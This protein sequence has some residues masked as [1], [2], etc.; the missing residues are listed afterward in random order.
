MREQPF[1]MDVDG[2]LTS[3][4]YN[5]GNLLTLRKNHAMVSIALLLQTLRPLLI[6]T[7]RPERLRDVTEQWLAKHGLTPKQ[8]YMRPNDEEGVPDYLIKLEHLMHIRDMHGEPYF[9]ADDNQYVLLMLK[10]NAVP[11]I[12]LRS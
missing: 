5:D 10:E 6:S 2:T 4:Y 3:E 7:A 12:P 8:V 9:W 11:V 1:V